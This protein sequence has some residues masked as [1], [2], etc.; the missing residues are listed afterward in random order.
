M[1][2]KALSLID[3][4]PGRLW[5]DVYHEVR[6]RGEVVEVAVVVKDGAVL[7]DAYGG[8]EAVQGSADGLALTA[9]MSVQRGGV[10]EV[11]ERAQPQDVERL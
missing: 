4:A 6:H 11:V 7:A 2:R 8:D 10:A 5:C 9:G 1:E 3:L